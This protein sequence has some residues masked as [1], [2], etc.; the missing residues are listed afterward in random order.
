MTTLNKIDLAC[1]RLGTSGT[2]PV[3]GT[4]RVGGMWIKRL[5][6]WNTSLSDSNMTTLTT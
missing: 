5:Q 4:A 3:T 1:Q 6:Y 2:V